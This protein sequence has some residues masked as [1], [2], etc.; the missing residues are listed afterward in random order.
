MQS[1]RRVLWV[2]MLV[3][4]L[5]A[6]TAPASAV[7]PP[8]PQESFLTNRARI[9]HISTVLTDAE[10]PLAG[11][12]VELRGSAREVNDGAWGTILSVETDEQGRAVVEFLPWYRVRLRWRWSG[13]EQ[14]AGDRSPIRTLDVSSLA[15]AR[16]AGRPNVIRGRLRDGV[17]DALVNRKV[18]LQRR[19][20]RE[21]PW[22]QARVVTSDDTGRLRA[23]VP[24]ER[25]AGVR[26]RWRGTPR[27]AGST[28]EGVRLR[29]P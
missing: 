5:V 24:F 6:P 28:S 12:T 9:L 8:P 22:K 21:C 2:T 4:A 20:C 18:A 10:G 29:L 15:I 23:T 19:S 27:I 3:C 14:H 7:T 13:D 16:V 17:G 11:R 1:L 26:W 25:G